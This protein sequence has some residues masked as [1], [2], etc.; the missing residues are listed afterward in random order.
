MKYSVIKLMNIMPVN[1][2][3]ILVKYSA[4]F[5]LVLGFQTHD[6]LFPPTTQV[7]NISLLFCSRFENHLSSFWK[8]H[9][10]CYAYVHH[11]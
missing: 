4:V 5:A 1:G 8:C 7:K 3:I 9:N 10:D 2:T 11:T 6:F